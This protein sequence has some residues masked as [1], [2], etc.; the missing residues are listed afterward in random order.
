MFEVLGSKVIV[1]GI[2]GKSP[3]MSCTAMSCTL[4]LSSVKTVS[5]SCLDWYHIASLSYI[6]Y[7][8]GENAGLCPHT[9]L[10]NKKLFSIYIES[11]NMFTYGILSP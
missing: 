5:L 8:I 4:V 11:V 2:L 10:G 1:T 6:L 9:L 3:A 7:C